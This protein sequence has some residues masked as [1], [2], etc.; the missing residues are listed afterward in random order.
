LFLKNNKQEVIKKVRTITITMSSLVS[1]DI[2]HEFAND[3]VKYLNESCTAFHA[4]DAARTRLVSAGYKELYLGNKWILEKKGKYF[5]TKNSTSIIAFTIGGN[6]NIGNGLTVL[7]AHTDSPCFKIKPVTCHTKLNSLMLNTQPYGGGLWYTWFDRDLGIAGRLIVR[8][9]DG[10][11]QT[12]LV[13]IDEP[14]ARIPS[15]AIHLDRTA[16]EKFSPNLHDHCQAILSCDQSI[17]NQKPVTENENEVASR[18]HPYLLRMMAK[19]ANID[20]EII[21][22]MEL[23]LIDVQPSTLGC[24]NDELLFSGRLDNLCST[25]QSLRALIDSS[26]DTSLA[27]QQNICMAMLFDHEEVGSDSCQGAG[28][29]IFMDTI[30]LILSVMG[31]DSQ[32]ALMTTLS[33][34]F[35]CSVDMAHAQHPNYSGKHDS[36]MAP[37]IN[38]ILQTLLIIIIIMIM[39]I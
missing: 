26:D 29:S 7:G 35:I 8:G 16:N 33:N 2:K 18:L 31:D 12:K 36:T 22:D 37:K 27:S 13:R 11:I 10:D 34:S 1:N 4:V 25:Y 3:F 9:E 20:P 23:Q 6:Y 39:I 30:R 19:A 24:A 38:G 21:E 15:L 17:A 14:I 32:T 28:S 5:F